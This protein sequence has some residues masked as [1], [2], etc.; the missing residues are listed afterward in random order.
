LRAGENTTWDVNWNKI[1]V[2]ILNITGLQD[3]V[4]RNDEV[5]TELLAQLQNVKVIEYADA[6]HMIPIETPKKLTQD[7]LK[8]TERL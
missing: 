3:Q 1:D 4:F 7:I 5:I 2:P 6:G 8:F